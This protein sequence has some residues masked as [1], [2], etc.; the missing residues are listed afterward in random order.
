MQYNRILPIIVVKRKVAIIC[1]DIYTCG[2]T[3][4]QSG[5]LFYNGSVKYMRDIIYL[6]VYGKFAFC[7]K[8]HVSCIYAIA[9]ILY[10]K[11]PYCLHHITFILENQKR[12]ILTV[13]TLYTYRT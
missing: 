7:I 9:G 8:L 12:D 5:K 1:S 13:G 11:V 6:L 3:V 10:T 2:S 4:V